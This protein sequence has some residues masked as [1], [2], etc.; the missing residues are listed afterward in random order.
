MIS[1]TSRPTGNVQSVYLPLPSGVLYL[2]HPLLADHV[3]L[4][5][6]A[7]RARLMKKMTAAQTKMTMAMPVGIS[8][9]VSSSAFEPSIC[10]APDAASAVAQGKDA[11]QR[12]NQNGEEDGQRRPGKKYSAST[13]ARQVPARGG[14][15]GKFDHILLYV[16]PVP[17][18]LPRFFSCDG[19]SVA[20]EAAKHK[21]RCE[22][23][24]SRTMFMI[25][26][27]YCPVRGS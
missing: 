11:N 5:G 19:T 25:T 22:A 18:P 15:N 4:Q 10:V 9:Q 23:A 2:P 14:N 27:P 6:I 7:R 17:A 16:R 20:R 24:A 26:A 12:G 3:N 1:R 13:C 8:V 21:H